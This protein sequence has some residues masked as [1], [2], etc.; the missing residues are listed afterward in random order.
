[1]IT[2]FELKHSSKFCRCF[3]RT[4]YFIKNII[5]LIIMSV[6]LAVIYF[7][8]FRKD[9]LTV[10]MISK[11]LKGLNSNTFNYLEAHSTS[12]RLTN[13][14]LI[15]NY[16]SDMPTIDFVSECLRL[17]RPCKF[18]AMATF[19]DAFKYWKFST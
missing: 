7:L 6:M 19:W 16:D 3:V 4:P 18:E 11:V 13:N 17:N 10:N 2:L 15:S 12:L 1:M 5:L 14:P 9:C 8:Y